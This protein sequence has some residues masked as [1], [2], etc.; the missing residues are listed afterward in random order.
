MRG[1]KSHS[2]QLKRNTA[3]ICYQIAECYA[4]PCFEVIRSLPQHLLITNWILEPMNYNP[5]RKPRDE[6]EQDGSNNS[7]VP[8]H[9]QDCIRSVLAPHKNVWDRV[10]DSILSPANSDQKIISVEDKTG[11]RNLFRLREVLATPKNTEVA[12]V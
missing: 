11:R 2:M 8:Q 4:V 5:N 12:N 6:S 9:I 10:Q 3:I 7:I 1:G